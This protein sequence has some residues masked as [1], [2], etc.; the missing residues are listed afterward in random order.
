MSGRVSAG[1]LVYRRRGPA[2][3]V[4]LVHPGGPFWRARDEGAWS[5]PKG[6]VREGEDLLAT[7]RREMREETGFAPEGPYVPLA[8]VRQPGG[9][10]IHAWAVEADWDPSRLTS[11]TFSMEWPPRSGRVRSFPEVDRAAWFELGEARRRILG[12]Q[13]GL[14][15]QLAQAVRARADDRPGDR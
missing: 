8:P 4:L 14:L 13:R 6:E 12:G 9:K 2:V 15:E 11:G 5:V 1:L 10:V 7:A 3:E